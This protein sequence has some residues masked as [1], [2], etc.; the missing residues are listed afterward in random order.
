MAPYVGIS[1]E[2]F[3]GIIGTV[4]AGIALGSW[5]GGLAADRMDPARLIG[6]SMIVGGALAWLAL[7]IVR[8][9]GPN[10]GSGSLGIIVLTTCAFL[11]PAAVLSA[12]SPMVAKLR[13]Q[14]LDDTGFVVGGLSAAGTFGA[15]AGTF[16]T[17][18]VLVSALPTRPI[19]IGIGALLVVAG[20]SVDFW[21][22]GQKPTVPLALLLVAA[23]LLSFPMES[24]CD[25]E[26]A[27]FC[28]R[29]IDDADGGSGRSLILDRGR[30]AFVDLEDPTNLDIRYIRLLA[31]VAE[32]YDGGPN[33]VLHVGGG[34]FSLPRYLHHVDDDVTSLVFEIDADLVQI[35]RDELGLITDDRLQVQTGDA[36]L[37]MADLSD[38]EFDLIIGDAFASKTVPWHLTTAEFIDEVDRVLTDDGIYA[39][40]VIDGAENRFAR[41]ELATLADQFEHVRVI[42]PVDGIADNAVNQILLASHQPI[43]DM[44]FGADG[45]LVAGPIEEF[46]DG[47]APLRDDFAPVDQLVL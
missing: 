21:L 8:L 2:T 46:I 13:L 25:H 24:P 42:V 37:A 27:Y 40:N 28:V 33:R 1:L 14:S 7:P 31:A 4:L 26:T 45:V 30:Q 38:G 5:A 29:I 35:N 36:R 18:F 20:F 44:T 6:P 23:G 47:Q 3:T 43:P 12:V 41:A 17:G 9:L 39:M 16:I 11:L 15:L 10:V 22:R 32:T 19:V 34:G